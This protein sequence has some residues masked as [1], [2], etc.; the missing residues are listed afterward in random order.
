MRMCPDCSLFSARSFPPCDGKR[1]P[2]I[3]EQQVSRNVQ[4]FSRAHGVKKNLIKIA[5]FRLKEEAGTIMSRI[6]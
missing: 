1:P 3:A 6:V 2:G 4:G 5:T